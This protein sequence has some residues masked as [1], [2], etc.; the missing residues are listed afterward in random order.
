LAAAKKPL[1][2]TMGSLDP[3]SMK[4]LGDYQA[5]LES[6]IEENA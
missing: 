6:E 2:A 4:M 5:F 3:K 1:V